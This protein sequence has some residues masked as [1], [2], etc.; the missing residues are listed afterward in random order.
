MSGTT[1]FMY[2]FVNVNDKMVSLHS[3]SYTL[4]LF[5]YYQVMIGILDD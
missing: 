1:L 4:V 2:T 5:N 3:H